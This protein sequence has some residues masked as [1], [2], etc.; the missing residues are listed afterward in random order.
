MIP[1]APIALIKGGSK[2]RVPLNRDLYINGSSSV[3]VDCL[4]SENKICYLSYEWTCSGIKFCD[5][6]TSNYGG[7]TIPKN[8]LNSE[9]R[10]FFY[11]HCKILINIKQQG[12]NKQFTVTLIVESPDGP[13]SKPYIQTL[14]TANEKTPVASLM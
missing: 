3:N 14:T 9:V 11:S 1:S 2:K 13:R 6:F 10:H 8:E 12:E 7:F 5:G 4:K